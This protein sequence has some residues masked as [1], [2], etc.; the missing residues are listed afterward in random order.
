MAPTPRVP[1]L[2]LLTLTS[3]TM[4]TPLSVPLDQLIRTEAAF[5]N[6]P[7][8]GPAS[9]PV[10]NPTK[11]YWLD[12]EEGVNPLRSHGSDGPLIQ[13]ADICIIGSGI[14]GVSAAW[15]LAKTLERSSAG[16]EKPLDVVILEARDFCEL[17]PAFRCHLC[18]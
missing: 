14:T 13:D 8:P 10:P 15:H 1:A 16:R 3:L 2:L 5:L 12:S 18:R 6:L 9:L 17:A 7:T 4:S 11:S